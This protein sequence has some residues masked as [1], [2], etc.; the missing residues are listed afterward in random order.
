[1]KSLEEILK[2]PP[3]FLHNFSDKEDVATSFRPYDGNTSAKDIL[4]G[5]N[6]LFA[7]YGEDNWSGDAFVLFEENGKLYEVFGSHCSCYGLE[8]QF[9]PSETTL[10]ALKL[11]LDGG[12]FGHDTW[13][14]NEFAN[15]LR[16]FIGA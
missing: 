4:N 3:V 14:G 8:G 10:E 12:S 16:D 15:E 2:Q 5:R 11:A 7:S 6:F 1:M 13:S 9:D